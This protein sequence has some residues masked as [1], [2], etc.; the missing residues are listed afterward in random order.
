MSAVIQGYRQRATWTA[1]V[2]EAGQDRIMWLQSWIG[3][4]LLLRSI[5]KI[6]NAAV[7]IIGWVRNNWWNL[8]DTVTQ[9]F[10]SM[11]FMRGQSIVPIKMLPISLLCAWLFPVSPHV[12]QINS[13]TL[14][15]VSNI[16][17]SYKLVTTSTLL[18]ILVSHFFDRKLHNSSTDWLLGRSTCWRE[19]TDCSPYSNQTKQSNE[20][21]TYKEFEI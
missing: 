7:S 14:L 19:Y 16:Q 21:I 9:L 13:N 6:T 20:M 1:E 10:Y 5:P 17:C 2:G 4:S 15:S 11:C 18:Y 3:L 12:G 8:C